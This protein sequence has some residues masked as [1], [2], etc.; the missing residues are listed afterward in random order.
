MSLAFLGILI[1]I[2]FFMVLAGLPRYKNSKMLNALGIVGAAVLIAFLLIAA[3][4][5]TWDWVIKFI[6][7]ISI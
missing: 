7:L 5:M 2:I 1:E 6:E 4:A 3:V